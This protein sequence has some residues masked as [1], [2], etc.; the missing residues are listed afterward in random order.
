MKPR[1][2]TVLCGVA[3]LAILAA[4]GGS[5]AVAVRNARAAALDT[6]YRGKMCLLHLAL[7]HY[8]ETYGAYP[9]IILRDDRGRPM[10]SWRALLLP[11]VEERDLARRYRL[12]E[13]WD[14]PHNRR[15]ITDCPNAYAFSDDDRRLGTTGVVAVLGQ[16]PFPTGDNVSEWRDADVT[17]LGLCEA[18]SLAIPWSKPDDLGASDLARM[19]SAGELER[20]SHS[21]RSLNVHGVRPSGGCSGVGLP[22]NTPAAALLDGTAF[23]RKAV[24]KP[25][26]P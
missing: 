3:I 20:L 13:P 15:L 14:S 6:T 16:K 8:H 11:F 25:S 9:P 4:V 22:F 7:F 1:I 21:G 23:D 10:H 26:A 19:A 2:G 12:D 5:L 18:N 17:V 24:S